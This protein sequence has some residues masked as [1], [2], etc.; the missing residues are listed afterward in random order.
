MQ[1]NGMSMNLNV[2]P[3]MPDIVINTGPIIA[4]VAATGNLKW[5]PSLY[6]R[7]LIPYEVF[8]EIEVGGLSNKESVALRSIESQIVVGREKTQIDA[9]ILRELDLGESSVIANALIHGI[10]TVAIDEKAGRRLARIH[11]LKVTGSL[12]ILLKARRHSL[13][14]SIGEC[15]A[16]MRDHGIWISAELMDEALRRANEG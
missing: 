14:P 12:G 10:D 7:I 1:S 8:K 9:A 16:L 4:M 2:K 13:I 6:G 3:I 11:G 15:I 5:L